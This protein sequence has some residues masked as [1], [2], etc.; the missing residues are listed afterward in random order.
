M[1]LTIGDFKHEGTLKKQVFFDDKY[2]DVLIHSM[3]KEDFVKKEEK[4]NS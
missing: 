2:H 4:K 1:L 3:F